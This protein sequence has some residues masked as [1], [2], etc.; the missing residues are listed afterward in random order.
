MGSGEDDSSYGDHDM[1]EDDKNIGS[2]PFEE[3]EGR[4]LTRRGHHATRGI[5]TMYVSF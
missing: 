1:K 4:S 5:E 2:N 3:V